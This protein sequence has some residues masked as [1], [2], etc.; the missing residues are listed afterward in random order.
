M[1]NHKN[2]LLST[3]LLL[4]IYSSS[5]LALDTLKQAPS[6]NTLNNAGFNPEQFLTVKP[7][8]AIPTNELQS[9]QKWC[10]R[11]LNAMAKTAAAS[12]NSVTV[13]GN[14]GEYSCQTVIEQ[15]R[16]RGF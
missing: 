8:P 4:G 11:A 12:A 5:A 6:P 3:L 7:A 13:F 10:Q 2:S 1:N 9:A 16:T 15:L 14:S